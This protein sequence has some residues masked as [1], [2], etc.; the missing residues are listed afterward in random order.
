MKLKNIDIVNTVNKLEKLKNKR[1]PQ[2]IS[3]AI[4]KNNSIFYNEYSIYEKALQ[5]IF[6]NYEEY[7][8]KDDEGNTKTS[9]SGIPLV[10][11][12][13]ESEFINEI[14]ELLKIDVEISPYFIDESLFDY[15]DPNGIYDVLTPSEIFLLV[16][17]LC[18]KKDK[19]E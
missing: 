1:L 18:E 13:K 3:Y 12:D 15:D 7:F 14:D 6:K 2:R 16:D 10:Q 11:K 9:P 5:Q 17:I 19:N 4:M 8:Q